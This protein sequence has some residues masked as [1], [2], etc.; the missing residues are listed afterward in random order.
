MKTISSV[1]EFLDAQ[2][3]VLRLIATDS[4]LTT[5]LSKVCELID[6]FLG[7]NNVKSSILLAENN[8]LAKGFSATLPQPYFDALIGLDIGPTVSPCSSAIHSGT[9]V[10]I[11]D[12]TKDP[13]LVN[14]QHLITDYSLYS[15]WA[16]PVFDNSECAVGSLNIYFDEPKMPDSSDIQLI[17]K[18]SELIKV[19]LVRT[20]EAQDLKQTLKEIT[21]VNQQL[22]VFTSVLPDLG[23]ITD[24]HGVFVESFGGNKE[25]L[26]YPNRSF[27]HKTIQETLPKEIASLVADAID[28]LFQSGES[29]Q[30]E[31][32][33]D[34]AIGRRFFEARMAELTQYNPDDQAKRYVLSIVRDITDKKQAQIEAERLAFYDPLT[35]LPNRR[36][37][38]NRLKKLLEKVKREKSY[39]AVLFLDLDNFKRINDSLGH[40]IGDK[41][42]QQTAHRLKPIIRSTDTLA[43]LGGDEFIILIENTEATVDAIT[44]E[45][46]VI[47]KKLLS[48]F[49]DPMHAGHSSF[50]L[51]CSI[52]IA[53]FN[54]TYAGI[55]DVLKQADAAMYRSKKQSGNEFSFFDPNLQS[56]IDQ[57]IEIERDIIS[58]ITEQQFIA[59]FQ[60]QVSMSGDLIGVEA[61]VRW[62]HPVKGILSPYLFLSVAEQFGLIQKI[63]HQVFE[64]SCQLLLELM[65]KE[66]TTTNFSIAVNLSAGEF[67][68]ANLATRLVSIVNKYQLLPSFFKLEI[69]ESMLVDKVEQSI[70]QMEQLKEQGF[71]LSIDDF[72]TGYSSLNYLHTFPINELKIDKSFIDKMVTSKS[73]NAIIN[74]IISLAFNLD[75]KVIAE[76]VET[77]EQFSILK[78]KYVSSVQ[79]Y[80]FAKPMPKEDL[81]SWISDRNRISDSLA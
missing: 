55:D 66:L 52:G 51:C 16:T 72:G 10:I 56:I 37:V 54:D 31:Y 61:L 4:D 64:Q 80:Y 38:T 49:K 81:I 36:L 5:I 53:I 17:D 42:L 8:K 57:Q 63:E 2:Q 20:K 12:T 77:E 23:F 15:C 68:S 74:A 1:T 43:R 13:L 30:I 76:G 79:G 78:Q 18:L 41:L 48:A 27:H 34:V 44:E 59:Y 69:T 65:A 47:A 28:K 35:D 6:L 21:R 40:S 73:G 60:P 11:K 75:I 33:L 29:Q 50:Q 25:L 45:V 14:F 70:N 67:K 71:K 39:G 3:E 22:K 7:K 19:A 26:I 62:A 46:T 58:A 32:E 24:E 9:H